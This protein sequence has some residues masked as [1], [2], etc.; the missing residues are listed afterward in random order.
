M[1]IEQI[2][3]VDAQILQRPLN[4]FLD[5]RR[6]SSNNVIGSV[7]EFGCKEDCVAL[8]CPLEPGVKCEFMI[9]ENEFQT[10]SQS[11]LQNLRRHLKCPSGC[12]LEQEQRP[13]P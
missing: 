7:T 13:R 2:D 12:I 6:V 1:Q 11:V 3:C 8:S 5:K 4:G 10:I 9:R